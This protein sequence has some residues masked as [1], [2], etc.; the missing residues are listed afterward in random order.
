ME[1]VKGLL[2]AKLKEER[3]FDRILADLANPAAAMPEAGGEA[4]QYQMIPLTVRKQKLGRL[5]IHPEDFVVSR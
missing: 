1:N 5:H 3:I 4:V 2:S